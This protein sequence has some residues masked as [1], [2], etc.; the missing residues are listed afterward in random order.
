MASSAEQETRLCGN[1][2]HDVPADNFTMHEVHCRRKICICDLCKEPVPRSNLEDHL[3]TEHVTVTCKCDMIMEKCDLEE[4]EKSACPLRLVKCQF[5]ELEVTFATLRNHEDYCGAR[6]E[7]CEKCGSSVM[8]KDLQD[9]PTV[10]GKIKPPKKPARDYSWANTRSFAF[11]LDSDIFDIM[12]KRPLRSDFHRSTLSHESRDINQ[13][14]WGEENEGR[15]RFN[16]DFDRD[17]P[18]DYLL[19]ERSNSVRS[20]DNIRSQSPQH[21]APSSPE[22]YSPFPQ[23]NQL[24]SHNFYCKDNNMKT[25]VRGTSNLNYFS[26]NESMHLNS[27]DT[28]SADV[29]KLPCE[30]CDTLYAEDFLIIH[31]SVCRPDLFFPNRRRPTSPLPH[32][33][34]NLR[35]SSN[36]AHD[37]QSPVMIPCEFC[38]VLIEG[39]VLFHHQVQCDMGPTSEKTPSLADHVSAEDG[40]RSYRAP[41]ALQAPRREGTGFSRTQTRVNTGATSRIDGLYRPNNTRRSHHDEMRK[42]NMEENARMIQD[43][44]SLGTWGASNRDPGTRSK[45][46]KNINTRSDDVDTEE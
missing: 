23:N 29:I 11:P 13:N 42:S 37:P 18:L 7:L 46:K 26:N 39:E 9:H 40:H 5:C 24:F 17:I 10:C 3:A 14:P 43:D 25:N 35:A 22:P 15:E 2:K 27:P 19:Q 8:I 1:C 34:E 31:Q 30:F 4:H 20:S 33:T 12:P 44:G 38:G 32:F 36:S 16:L 45:P 41:V 21:E 6:T 28:P